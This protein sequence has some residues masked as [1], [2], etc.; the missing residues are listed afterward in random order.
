[1][2]APFLPFTSEKLH[3][4]LGYDAPLFGTQITETLTDALGEHTVL[5]YD[6]A[7]A[8]GRWEA[9]ALEAGRVLRQPAPLFKKLDASII[10]EEHERMGKPRG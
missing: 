3:S 7:S 1:M 9:V 4:F 6:P 8:S 10:A 2:L 5:R